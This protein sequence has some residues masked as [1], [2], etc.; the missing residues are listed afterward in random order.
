MEIT[1]DITGMYYRNT[2][3]IDKEN[4]TVF[5]VMQAAAGVRAPNGG[6]M[7]FTTVDKNFMEYP[8]VNS[9]TV[10]YDDE[11]LPMT[12]QTG[13]SSVK[14]PQRP[15]GVYTFNDN[16][17]VSESQIDDGISYQI[18][19]QYYVSNGKTI[20]NLGVD[21]ARGIVPV[22]NSNQAPNGIPLADGDTITWRLVA[23]FGLA[24]TLESYGIEPE[25]SV[26]NMKMMLPDA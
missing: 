24:E 1:I 7:A 6:M 12:R 5:D 9:I 10:F 4:P 13:A 18:A 23:I 26:R 14:T 3:N 2:V 22:K 17:T 20:K 19:W 25:G 16:N 11:S 8:F 21:G 15:K